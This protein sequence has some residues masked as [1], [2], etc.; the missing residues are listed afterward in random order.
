MHRPAFRIATP[1]E[2]SRGMACH[3]RVQTGPPSADRPLFN[4]S[5]P[6]FRLLS[7][8]YWHPAPPLLQWTQARASS[9][10]PFPEK[11]MEA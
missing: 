1:P 10:R 3:A 5:I 7:H 9:A 8:P 6:L 4:I 2:N 11:A